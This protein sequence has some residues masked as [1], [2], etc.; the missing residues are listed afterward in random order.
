MPDLL[1]QRV[2]RDFD[3]DRQD[4]VPLGAP[5]GEPTMWGHIGD[6]VVALPGE[7]P[8]GLDFPMQGEGGVVRGVEAI[9][10]GERRQDEIALGVE[11]GRV[12]RRA[13]G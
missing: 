8:V 5:H 9:E 13:R 7:G 6:Q 1:H 2:G 11:I 10:G 3:G 12:S 4:A